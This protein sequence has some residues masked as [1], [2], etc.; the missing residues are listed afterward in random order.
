MASCNTL[1]YPSL[2]W[3]T[4]VA[5][6]PPPR[7]DGVPRPQRNGMWQVEST[8][9]SG[10]RPP[11]DTLQVHV[12]MCAPICVAW[13][14]P[15]ATVRVP[16]AAGGWSEPRVAGVDATC[17]AAG[18]RF[19]ASDA[20][21]PQAAHIAAQGTGGWRLEVLEQQQQQQHEALAQLLMWA[22]RPTRRLGVAFPEG[23]CMAT[24]SQHSIGEE[25]CHLGHLGV[26]MSAFI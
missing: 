20:G 2:R 6:R 4:Q 25:E 9:L 12:C 17:M 23:P 1:P 16:R 8:V 21:G 13:Y 3:A 26:I 24:S 14:H 18:A 7:S 22:P 5:T 10:V 11:T 19:K 15:E